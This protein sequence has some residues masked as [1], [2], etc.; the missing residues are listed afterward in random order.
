MYRPEYVLIKVPY[1]GSTV[2]EKRES[3]VEIISLFYGFMR[4]A[5]HLASHWSHRVDVY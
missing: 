4:V 2:R 3:V 5:R 1:T